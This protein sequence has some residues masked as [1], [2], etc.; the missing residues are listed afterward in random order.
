[1][2][3]QSTQLEHGVFMNIFG[4]GVLLTGE[5]GVGKSELALALLDRGHQLIADDMVEFSRQNGEVVGCAPQKLKNFLEVR[6]LGIFNIKV[7]FGACAVLDQ[8]IL[9]LIVHLQ[10]V[11]F[12]RREI[13]PTPLYQT[14]YDKVISRMILPFITARRFE[15]LLEILVRNFQLQPQHSLIQPGI[16]S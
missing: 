6:G 9:S 15:L 12:I 2:N 16:F 14:I 10:K 7:I 3:S 11:D 8:Q 4:L 13:S 5:S 1:M